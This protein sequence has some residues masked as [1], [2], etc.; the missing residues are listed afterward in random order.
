MRLDRRVAEHITQQHLD[1]LWDFSDAAASE[2][3]F[4]DAVEASSEASAIRAELT[5]QLARAIGLQDRFD[6]AEA[7]LARIDSGDDVVR[8]R[9]L[10]ERGRLRNSGG[11]P[12]AAVG[13]FEEALVAATAAR[14]DFLAADAAH[15][16]AIADPTQAEQWTAR[17]LEII[18][19]T[20]DA[21]T[22]RWAVGLHNNVGWKL[23][24][25]GDIDGA[26]AEFELA[27][28]AARD[29]GTV[30]QQRWAQ[31]AIDEVIAARDTDRASG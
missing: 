21:R 18:A 20:D 27:A 22:K 5:T 25:D 9:V 29:Y 3:R 16:L 1:E 2:E 10:L 17:G 6:D 8:A 12:D 31:E 13:L 23:F 7:V 11:H 26:L 24:D 14:H 15:M 30:D 19:A 28:A 4:R